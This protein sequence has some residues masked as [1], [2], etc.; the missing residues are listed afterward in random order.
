[1]DRNEVCSSLLS[2][3]DDDGGAGEPVDPARAAE[4]LRTELERALERDPLLSRRLGRA[5]TS[6]RF[7]IEGSA[8]G[9]TV[10]LDRDPLAVRE[11]GEPAEIEIT[12]S[13]RQA[14]SLARGELPIAA[15]AF[16][17]LIEY[18][19]PVRKFLE[20]DPILQRLVRGE[21]LAPRLEPAHRDASATDSELL[22]IQTEGLEKSFDSHRVLDGVDLQ[23][24]E[25]LISVV[26]GPSG[27]GK[28][29]LFQHIIG[30]LAPDRGEVR[31]RGASLAGMRRSDLTRLRRVVGVMFQDGALFSA[32]NVFDNVAFPLREHT[33]LSDR[34][35]R[36]IVLARLRDVGLEA[37]A[38]SFPRELSGGMRKRAGLARAL[39]LDPGILLCDEP[40]SGL[41]PVR[42]SLIGDLLM[43]QHA[44]GGGAVLVVT[45]DIALTRQ[46]ADHVSVL[47][48]GRIVASGL[49]HEVF[50]SDDEFVQQFLEGQV[51]GPLRME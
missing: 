2:D 40:D 35:T 36:E 14:V 27:T 33:D 44:R 45:H 15:A 18:R 19:G 12:L 51:D 10:L 22:A 16:A 20:I 13:A 31:L 6:V 49:A 41:D 50:D 4:Q 23:I 37:A 1:M 42:T 25:G 3:H 8:E 11:G 29:V 47:W 32:M 9:P 21:K 7:G 24:P 34:E 17:G 26:L 28:S 5:R 30:S 38:R 39:V 48:E 43:N 46:I